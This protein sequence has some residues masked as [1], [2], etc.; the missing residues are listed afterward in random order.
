[1]GTG[2]RDTCIAAPASH[3]TLRLPGGLHGCWCGEAHMGRPLLELLSVLGFGVLKLR[4]LLWACLAVSQ[5]LLQTMQNFW[6]NN[7][8]P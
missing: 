3:G 2:C 4:Q 1:M 6:V 7:D 8:S 5:L